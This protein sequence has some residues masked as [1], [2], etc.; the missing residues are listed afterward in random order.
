MYKII[1]STFLI[2]LLYNSCQ[3]KK[4]RIDFAQKEC[5][6]LVLKNATYSLEKAP[7]T[8]GQF[9]GHIQNT[10]RIKVDHNNKM[11]CLEFFRISA[12]FLRSDGSEISGV[13]YKSEYK[14]NDPEVTL[15]NSYI[16]IAFK[17]TMPTKQDADELRTIKIDLKLE[18]E[19]KDVSKFFTLTI[20]LACVTPSS[21]GNFQVV[22]N[23]Y[24]N[25]STVSLSFRDYSSIDGDVIS[26][27]LNGNIVPGAS[28]LLLTGSFQTFYVNINSGQNTLVVI[29]ENEGDVSP[30]TCEVRVN[31]GSGIDLTPGLSTGQGINIIF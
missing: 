27:Y 21:Q 3:S 23:V 29:A 16:E 5:K 11:A 14:F 7:C 12:L 13:A 28:H 4:V 17:Y 9:E 26:V 25:T 22:Q 1:I 8:Q 31:N 6:N 18:N 10:I 20:P 24:V 2:I 19:L 15:T 30:N